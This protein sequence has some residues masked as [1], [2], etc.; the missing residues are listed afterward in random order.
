M[1]LYL[2]LF[3]LLGSFYQ[4]KGQ[5]KPEEKAPTQKEVEELMK[6]AQ[7]MMRDLSDEDKKAMDSLGIKMPVFSKPP[8]VSNK[9]LA[10]AW[11]DENRVVPKK[12]AA[13]IA[14]V[15]KSVTDARMGSYLAAIG[16]KIT[17]TLDA[18][19]VK[20][21]DKIYSY[22][23]Q[24]SK[25]NAAAGN[26]TVAFWLAGKPQLAL[27]TLGK[28]CSN[29]PSNADNL[30]NYA[31]MLSMQ[32][33]QHLA[34]PILNNLNAKFPKNS[35]L[36]NNLG[37]AWLG[38]GELVKAEKYLDSAL[39]LYP[40]HPQANMAKAAIAESKGNTEKA[41]EAIKKCMQHAYTPEKEA[42]LAKLGQKMSAGDVGLPRRSKADPMNLGG[43]RPPDFPLSVESCA[44]LGLEWIDFF[45]Q[46]DDKI[47]LLTQL[48]Q[49][50]NA[51]A[52]KGQF[53]SA[54]LYANRAAKKYKAYT[55][56]YQQK[57]AAHTKRVV[58]FIQGEGLSLK[59][60]Y[61]A[62]IKKIRK[63][64][65]DQ[66]G[67]GKANKSYCPRYKQAADNYLKA[68]NSAMQE[69]YSDG[70]QLKKEFL[71]ESAYY[72]MYLMWPEQFE[73]AK[74]D[75]Q[76][77]WLKT[78]K[79][80]LVTASYGSG[81]PFISITEYMCDANAQ[82]P[83][84]TKLQ[85]FDDVH[86][87]YKS[88]TDLHVIKFESNCSRLTSSFDVGFLEYV[89]KDDFERAEGDTYISS[90]VK[91]SAEAGKSTEKGPLKA[92]AKIAAGVEVELDRKGV[93]D[94]T[95][96]VEGKVGVGTNVFDEGM[97][98][99]GNIAGNDVWD[100]TIE[101]GVEGRISIMSGQGSV[102]GTGVLSGIS[103]TGW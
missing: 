103:L 99:H 9:Q 78:L 34:I 102:S 62:E 80:G 46:V 88:K 90:T 42:R 6:E 63:E 19:V 98:E 96:V 85:H 86:C 24:N 64:E 37:Q 75:F 22:L 11:E 10:D 38:L 54:P 95:L 101:A 59:N 49:N 15:P 61:E 93:K 71:N 20:M 69:F 92:E 30:S 84:K 48:K 28:V 16:K 56:L 94:V 25:N 8:K 5:A 55:D 14:A 50:A 89:R 45:K 70:L 66:I 12:D 32:G 81:F 65:N 47:G 72:T 40:L 13:R 57:L 67:E 76:I 36:L 73:M 44:K 31:A 53:V 58:S 68:V 21:G 41:R 97:E 33:A 91:V 52:A 3:L 77:D 83:K 43:F 60:A 1:R 100:T 7:Q 23:R 29:D 18:E 87:N 4:I 26:M 39:V 74:L 51:A 82:D 35:T 2:F 17:G 27:Y 79:K